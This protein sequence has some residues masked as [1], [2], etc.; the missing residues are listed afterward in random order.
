M[1]RKVVFY[2]A[3]EH[4]QLTYKRTK[5]RIGNRE[6]IAFCDRDAEKQGKQFLGLPVMSFEAAQEQ[7]ADFDIYI[8]ANERNAPNIIGFLLE[9]GVDKERILNYEPVEKRLG[10]AFEG[11]LLAH[12]V[13]EHISFLTCDYIS[14]AGENRERNEIFIPIHEFNSNTMQDAFV[15]LGIIAQQD[16]TYKSC[17]SCKF[18]KQQ[19]YFKN[20][21]IRRLMLGGYTACNYKCLCCTN[22]ELYKIYQADVYEDLYSIIQSIEDL[23]I[24]HEDAVIAYGVGEFTVD[25]R[26]NDFLKRIEK[27]AV[28]LFTNGYIYSEG[29]SNCL[30]RG[31]SLVYISIDAGTPETYMKIKGVDGFKRVVE[32]VYKYTASGM[33]VL[34]YIM[35]ENINTNKTDLEGFYGLADATADAVVISR[36]FYAEKMLSDSTLNLAAQFIAHFREN[37]KLTGITGYKRDGEREKLQQYLENLQDE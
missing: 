13:G 3:G 21:K 12:F 31:N 29:I 36:D 10:C 37:G 14:Q 28:M 17:E 20:K 22:T 19:Y 18:Y 7:F 5:D 27:Y 32:N 35:F 16:H 11:T 26:H 8:T 2:G 34:K 24:L 4:A 15:D 30:K 25:K 33:T 9:I 1:S 6:P 23:N